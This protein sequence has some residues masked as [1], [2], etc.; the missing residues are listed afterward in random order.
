MTSSWKTNVTFGHGHEQNFMQREPALWTHILLDMYRISCMYYAQ[1]P[2]AKDKINTAWSHHTSSATYMPVAAGPDMATH[3]QQIPPCATDL[4]MLMGS[5]L[6][7]SWTQQ[8]GTAGVYL[9][10]N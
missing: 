9:L 4:C 7:A 2:G 6:Y 8:A 5:T 3:L 10:C 1:H